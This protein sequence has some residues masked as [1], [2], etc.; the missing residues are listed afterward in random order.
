[1]SILVVGSVALDTIKTPFGRKKDIL[2][3]SATYFSTSAAFFSPVALVAV[4][5]DDF[6]ARHVAF[7][8]RR[9]V[10][11]LGLEVVK[12]GRTFKWEGEY[13]WDFADPRTVATHLN[14]FAGFDP[15]IPPEY[16]D[17]KF[18]FLANID[19]ALQIKV[20]G[21]MRNPR[22]VACDTMN[23]W[24]KNKRKELLRLLGKVDIFFLN[25][26]EARE[27]TGEAGIVR[28]ARSILKMGPA[29]LIIKKGEHGSLLFSGNS[30]FSVPAFLM[31]SIV[32]PTGAGDTYAGGVM[33]Y[34]AS[35]RSLTESDLR[36]AVVYGGV[37]ATFAAEGFSL[38]RLARTGRSEIEKRY[39]EF[40]KLTRF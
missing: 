37:M 3:G 15:A 34:L 27:L 17:K 28:A 9:K 39:K 21:Q 5:G 11:T 25:E 12:G 7:L 16:R 32:D 4:V 36:R 38:S 40:I 10:D 33:G 2:G 24:I 35:R 19:P 31:E 8:K 26:S 30:V 6:P 13:D 22:L 20:L 14:V 1:M 23:Y 18:V 29:K